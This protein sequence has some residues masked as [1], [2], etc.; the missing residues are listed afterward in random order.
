MAK[1]TVLN[2]L[3]HPKHRHPND[4]VKLRT[5]EKKIPSNLCKIFFKKLK[6]AFMAT[7]CVSTKDCGLLIYFDIN[8]SLLPRATM[9]LPSIH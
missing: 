7:F 4:W 8:E 3:T 2:C 5:L 9:Y 6:S 1:F